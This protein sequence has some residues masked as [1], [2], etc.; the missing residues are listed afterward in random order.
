[1]KVRFTTE[2]GD[3]PSGLKSFAASNPYSYFLANKNGDE[4]QLKDNT[5]DAEV[6]GF[7]SNGSDVRG[8]YQHMGT[9][10]GS[11]GP[12]YA[13]TGCNLA[14]TNA[15]IR[16]VTIEYFG[17]TGHGIDRGELLHEG[18]IDHNS[19]FRGIAGQRHLR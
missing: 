13:G 11:F 15:E 3:L 16:N 9:A 17:G 7:S 18:N 1:M 14:V 12:G 8:T 5:L 2:A 6:V 19:T 4:Y 10:I